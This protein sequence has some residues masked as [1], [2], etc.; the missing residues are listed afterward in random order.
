MKFELKRGEVKL[1]KKRFRLLQFKDITVQERFERV[2]QR[3][4]VT[5]K[6]SSQ[7]AYIHLIP[8]I[9]EVQIVHNRPPETTDY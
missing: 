4:L 7:V 3:S 1:S 6:P 5:N 9:P 2:V 8:F